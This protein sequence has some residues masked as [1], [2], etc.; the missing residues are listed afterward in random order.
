V[1][2]HGRRA[3]SNHSAAAVYASELATS[4]RPLI[5]TN[6]V[7]AESYTRIRYDD[8]H[9]KALAFDALLQEMQKRRILAVS[10][11]TPAIHH[12]ALEC[13][14]KYSDQEFSVV[15]CS[16]FV[17]ARAKRV[18]EVFGFDADFVT[19]GFTLRP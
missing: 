3:R 18:V 4:L 10:W 14:R 12:L 19:M 15:D 17:V 11:I 5:T 9:A 2:R 1:D 7:L 16:S 13:F 8:G 6:Y